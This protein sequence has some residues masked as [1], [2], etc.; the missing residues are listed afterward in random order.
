MA[1]LSVLIPAR[2]EEWLKQTI[3][4]VLAHSERDTEV[5]VVMDGAYADPPIP[6]H[7]KVQVIYGPSAIGQRAATNLAARIS[8][9]PYICKLDAHCSVAQGWDRVLL[10]SAQTLGPNCV[11]IPAQKNLH[12][13]DWVCTC[14]KRDYQGPR[15]PCV[16]CGGEMTREIVW[17]PRRGV[18]TTSWRLDSELHFQYWGEDQKRQQGNICDVMTSLGACMFLSRE[19]YWA[20]GGLDE[21]HGSWGQVGQELACKTWLSGGRHCVNRATWFAHFFRTGGIGFPYA[22]R[23]SEQEYARAY[24][25][26]LWRG[27]HWPGQTK[28]LR[29]L[30][31]KFWPVPGWTEAEREA[32]PTTLEKF[33]TPA[34][35]V[36]IAEAPAVITT[37]SK[38]IVYYSDCQPDPAILEASR[39]TIE[40]SGLPVVAVTLKPIDWPA[41]LNIVLPQ[42]RGY[43][44]MFQQILLGLEIVQ[45]ETV[46]FCEHD[47]L[48]HASHFDFTPVDASVPY[49]NQHVWKVSAEDGRALHY[50]CSQ[51][52]GLCAS[53][54]LLRQHYRKR[55]E[56]VE[57][58]GFSRR[59]GFEPGTH[60]RKERIDDLKAQTWMSPRPNIDIRHG[61]NLT[62]TRWKQSQFRNKRYCQGWTE[63]DGVPGW[64][65]T[66]G[67]FWEFLREMTGA[68]QQKVA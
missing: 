66:K 43:L 14:G 32:L 46:F 27:N 47:V 28:P 63:A 60:G 16:Q 68:L 15:H 45:A 25:R 37:P 42:K 29:W 4:D 17:K 10:D 41:A 19:Y 35:S 65:Q 20:L 9:A 67:R 44:T 49:Y 18:H 8:D 21:D 52:S 2:K 50:R 13:W 58:T 7:P 54:T 36:E 39:R 33:D 59:Q 57:S 48:Y 40:A 64:G 56:I 31:D 51:T 22:I 6:Q 12:V 62:A 3:D 34:S 61:A 1:E 24:A 5:I 55:V 11:Q 53:R 23:G 26:N 30:I 38:A